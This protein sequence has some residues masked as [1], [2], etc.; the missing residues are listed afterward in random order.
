MWGICLEDIIT[1]EIYLYQ[2]AVE[3]QLDPDS[4]IVNVLQP[5][6][7]I[8]ILS[9][10]IMTP[11]KP[12]AFEYG[13]LVSPDNHSD[14]IGTVSEIVWHFKNRDYNYYITVNS[15]KKSKRYYADDLIKRIC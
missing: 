3:Y 12:P 5:V 13:D 6:K 14:L 11:D 1:D 15:R 4:H 9:D 10:R 2:R 7:D 8:K